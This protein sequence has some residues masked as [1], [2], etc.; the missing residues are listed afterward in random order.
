MLKNAYLLAKIGDDTAENEL[1]LAEFSSFLAARRGRGAAAP[2]PPRRDAG[3]GPGGQDARAASSPD[4]T[5]NHKQSRTF[6]AASTPKIFRRFSVL[7]LE[8]RRLRDDDIGLK[9]PQQQKA[10][11]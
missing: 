1:N 10:I 4:V 9:N 5:E 6:C 11:S 2:G 8:R 3:R 7:V